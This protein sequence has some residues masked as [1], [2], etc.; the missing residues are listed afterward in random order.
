[1]AMATSYNWL[2]L[3]DYTF[4]FYG[5]LLVL[6]TN[7]HGHNCRFYNCNYGV[8][9]IHGRYIELVTSFHGVETNL[10]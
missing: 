6:I 4:Y 10:A 7:S 5:V 1:M 2:F 3:W 9:R 8:T